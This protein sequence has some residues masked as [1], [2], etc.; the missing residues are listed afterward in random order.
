M[1]RLTSLQRLQKYP[2]GNVITPI[3]NRLARSN[4]MQLS[5]QES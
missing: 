3:I 1:N 5:M 2:L 4:M